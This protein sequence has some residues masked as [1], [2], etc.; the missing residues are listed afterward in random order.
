VSF[1]D[2]SP[3][4]LPSPSPSPSPSPRGAPGA[5]H[6]LKSMDDDRARMRTGVGVRRGVDPLAAKLR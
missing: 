6:S 4:A 2:G 1:V 3:G 5:S